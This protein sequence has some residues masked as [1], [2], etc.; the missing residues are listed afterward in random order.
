MVIIFSYIGCI[1]SAQLSR[2]PKSIKILN[3]FWKQ[4][5]VTSRGMSPYFIFVCAA[6]SRIFASTCT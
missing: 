1:I 2:G 5:G 4:V 3:D 6:G